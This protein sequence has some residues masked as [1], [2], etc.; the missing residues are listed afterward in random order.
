M[1]TST[2][3]LTWVKMAFSIKPQ[4]PANDIRN[5]LKKEEIRIFVSFYE[6]DDVC[7]T[8]ELFPYT[9]WRPG[10]M[11]GPWKWTGL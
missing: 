11:S 2:A 4:L 9:P 10:L 8:N 7:M 6:K 3:L 5:Q 1:S